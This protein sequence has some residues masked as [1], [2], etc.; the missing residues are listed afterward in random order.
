M[1]NKF[2]FDFNGK[3]VTLPVNPEEL[4]VKYSGN[5]E[6][7]DMI[8]N[9]EMNF[10]KNKKLATIDIA[11][12]FPEDTQASYVISGAD[13]PEVY[14][15]FL[16]QIQN[17][18]KPFRLIISGTDINQQMLIESFEYGYAG[19]CNDIEYKL[20]LKEYKSIIYQEV[21]L[22]EE[23][24]SLV[25]ENAS[26]A[27][28]A[29]KEV[30]IGCSVMVNGQVHRDSYGG[31]LGVTLSNYKGIVNFINQ[32]GSKPYH[33]TNQNGGWLGWVSAESVEVL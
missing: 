28:P 23:S 2:Y 10:A 21:K 24:N 8:Q 33:V 22:L 31:G 18:R 26:R 30:T 12:F 29:N 6:S 15:S 32:S 1:H 3:V 5:N 11:S 20:S 25:N 19:G 14:L 9:G 4:W 27:E 7:V 13:D 17:S 16:K